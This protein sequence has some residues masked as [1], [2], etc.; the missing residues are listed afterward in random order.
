MT[1]RDFLIRLAGTLAAGLL[2]AAL[3]R[4]GFGARWF[5]FYGW[6]TVASAMAVA[7]SVLLWWRLP[8]TGRSRWWSLWV[9]APAT[10]AAAVQI[11]FWIA[12]GHLE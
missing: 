9:G 11:G 4:L 12:F 5:G 1:H 7:I 6:A 8:L 3:I 10:V 2:L